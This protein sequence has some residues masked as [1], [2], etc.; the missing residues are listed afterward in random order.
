M[1]G[2]IGHILMNI[3]DD[4]ISEA[5]HW[6]QK[7]IEADQRNQMMFHLGRDYA[8]YAQLFKRKGDTVK[9]REN[10]GKAIE[11][12]KE[13]RADGWVEKAEKELGALG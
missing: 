1:A 3:D 6:I 8:L 4:H 7:A 13:C 5:E 9:A 12:L 11:I 2:G 10:L